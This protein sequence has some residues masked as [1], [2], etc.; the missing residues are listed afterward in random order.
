MIR[1]AHAARCARAYARHAYR[2]RTFTGVMGRRVE[3]GRPGRDIGLDATP[4]GPRVGLA[5]WGPRLAAWGQVGGM[6]G[7]QPSLVGSTALLWRF[8]RLGV[9]GSDHF[10]NAEV[11]G[12]RAMPPERSPPGF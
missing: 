1:R 3:R 10:P 8:L 12:R 9:A 5:A 6:A 7:G 4:T 11:E 2:A